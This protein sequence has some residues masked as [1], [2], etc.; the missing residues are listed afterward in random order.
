MTGAAPVSFF[1]PSHGIFSKAFSVYKPF[2]NG[3]LFSLLLGKSLKDQQPF[4][5]YKRKLP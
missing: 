5:A 3:L 2:L 4:S 1:K